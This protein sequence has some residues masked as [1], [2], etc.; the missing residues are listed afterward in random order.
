MAHICHAR[1]YKNAQE[2]IQWVFH[3]PYYL[4]SN[5]MVKRDN[6]L[7]KKS[8]KPC[9]AQRDT[10]LSKVLHQVNNQDGPA[11]SP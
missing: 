6:S 8:F 1:K 4:Q 3:V 5:G 2:E 7:F 11:G 9:K 10:Q